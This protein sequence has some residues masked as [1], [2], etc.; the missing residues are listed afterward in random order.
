MA[1]KSF[2]GGIYLSYHKELTKDKAIEEVPIPPEI[3]IPLS[4]HA[5]APCEPL[6]KK[7]DKVVVG[8][9]IGDTQTFFS[10]PVHAPVNGVV[11]T[12]EFRP[13]F[14]GVPILSVVITA[15]KEQE[16]GF[17]KIENH[18]D[19][20]PDGL[21]RTIRE[22][23]IVG[24]GG[25]AFPTHVKLSPPKEKPIESVIINGCECEPY[26]TCDDRQ[27]IEKGEA[28]IDGL[29]LILKIVG[30][31]KGYIGVEDNKPEAISALQNLDLGEEIEVVPLAT[32]YPQGFEKKLIQ[33][34]LG[35]IVPL[36]GLPMD[37][38][39]VVQNVGTAI[40]V[41]EAIREGKPLIE[42]V[43]TVS[44]RAVKNPKNLRVKIGTP[45]QFLVDFCGGFQG[46]PG[47]II[48]GGPM[49]GVV[50]QDLSASVVKGNS[51]VLVL[52]PFEVGK[53][54]PVEP[55]IR[56]GECVQACPMSLLPYQLGNY[57]QV[58][59]WDGAEAFNAMACC[60]CAC[61]SF[62]CPANRPLVQWI[63]LAKLKIQAKKKKTA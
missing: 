58:E 60:E 1:L 53:Q 8:Q 48:L 31:K 4:Q 29:K 59:M 9:K 14:L 33:A 39:V 18:D 24:L 5:G 44:G 30:A 62:V 22:A 10:A 32:K 61:C 50:Q 21:K 3:I 25:A 35:K 57:G 63:K 7:G 45:A 38:G 46:K 55:C 36:G 23:G 28:L 54:R 34:I 11:K 26:L 43:I 49:T 16:P 40:A 20:S 6:V 15:D 12:V 17:K 47:K 2:K 51:G 27:M 56:C 41:S 37:V 52:S 13:H 19:L 42:R